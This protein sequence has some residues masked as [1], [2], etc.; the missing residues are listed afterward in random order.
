MPR[1][2]RSDKHGEPRVVSLLRSVTVKLP[3]GVLSL[4]RSNPD[5]PSLVVREGGT[6]DFRVDVA[7]LLRVLVVDGSPEGDSTE[8]IR[9]VC[10]VQRD[11]CSVL[12]VATQFRLGELDSRDYFRVLL[13]DVPS[14]VLGLL[15][16][17]GDIGEARLRYLEGAL[18]KLVDA[19]HG[20]TE[21]T[22]AHDDVPT[23]PLLVELLLQLT[24]LVGDG[25][26]L[27]FRQDSLVSEP[28]SLVDN[29][30]DVLDGRLGIFFL[31]FSWHF[32]ALGGR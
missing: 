23:L 19:H 4:G 28:D 32:R 26:R 7:R 12:E 18:D 8:G 5:S 14:D 15:V 27:G 24:W 31:G 9:V 17:R 25:N 13:E 2:V 29:L 30:V 22:V 10:S 3:K 21:T 6:D 16:G 20:L 1:P 11:S